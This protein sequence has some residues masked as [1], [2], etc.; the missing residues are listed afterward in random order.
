MYEETMR[1][2]LRSGHNILDVQGALAQSCNPSMIYI[3]QKN[4]KRNYVQIF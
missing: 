1:C 2:H 4:G 3:S